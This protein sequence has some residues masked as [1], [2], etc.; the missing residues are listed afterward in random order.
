MINMFYL[1]TMQGFTELRTE[2]MC[3]KG[4]STGKF[5]CHLIVTHG[6]IIYGGTSLIEDDR[7]DTFLNLFSISSLQLLCV[8]ISHWLMVLKHKM[9]RKIL[10]LK[11]DWF[12]KCRAVVIA[13]LKISTNKNLLC[14]GAECLLAEQIQ[15]WNGTI[16]RN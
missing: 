11:L 5:I 2:S 4:S 6:K 1:L 9:P 13:W 14:S 3:G 15:S 10:F 8:M 16:Y 7:S 12:G